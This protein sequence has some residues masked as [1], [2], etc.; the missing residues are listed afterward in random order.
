MALTTEEIIAT[1]NGALQIKG[2]EYDKN[3]NVVSA[4]LRTP[5]IGAYYSALAHWTISKRHAIIVMP[6][7]TGKT[8]TMVTLM[9]GNLMDKLLIIVPS[10]ALR[11]QIGERISKF[12]VLSEL[13]CISE[14]ATPPRIGYLK[15]GLKTLS[16]IEEF[17]TKFNVIIATASIFRNFPNGHLI[18]VASLC[19]H[20]FLDEAHHSQAP[21]TWMKIQKAFQNKPA[22]LFTATPYRNDELKL[23]GVEIYNYPLSKAQREGYFTEIEQ[24]PIY[25][26]NLKLADEAIA[27]KAVELLEKDHK[28]FP[29]HLLMARANSIARA[30]EIFTIYHKFYPQYNPVL[31]HSNLPEKKRKELQLQ[32]ENGESKIAVCVD[33]FGEGY[34]LPEIKIGAFHD[35]R[36]NITTALQLIGRFTRTKKGLGKAKFV[37]NAAEEQAAKEIQKLLGEDANWNILIPNLTE[38]KSRK[39][40]E[41]ST[42]VKSFNLPTKL[43]VQNLRP[44]LSLVVYKSAQDFWT[45]EKFREHF[46][47]KNLFH[48]NDLSNKKNTLIIVTAEKIQLD[49]MKSQEYFNI[50]H[51]LYV[52]HWLKKEKLLLIHSSKTNG[53]YYKGLAKALIGNDCRLVNGENVYRALQGIER[54]KFHGVGLQ[55]PHGTSVSYVQRAGKNVV[56]GTSASDLLNRSKRLLQGSGYKNGDQTNFGVSSKGRIWSL[57]RENIVDL[58]S[59]G[60]EIALKITDSSIDTS[61]FINHVA[62]PQLIEKRPQVRPFFI[63]W[64]SSLYS[65][66]YLKFSISTLSD[67][68][69]YIPN[70]DL[71]LHNPSSN[72]NLSFKI[73]TNDFVSH[74]ELRI[75]KGQQ[76]EIEHVGGP[77]LYFHDPSRKSL[78]EWLTENPPTIYFIDG[79]YLFDGNSYVKLGQKLRQFDFDKIRTIDWKTNGVNIRRESK[80]FENPEKTSIQF[81]LIENLKQKDSNY[82]LIFND[83]DKEE[84]ADIVTAKINDQTNQ[85]FIE[86]YHCKYSSEDN[87]GCRVGDLYEV[88]GQAQKNIR[89]LD[90]SYS[91][92]QRLISRENSLIN[93]NSKLTRIEKGDLA[94]L[95]SLSNKARRDYQILIKVFA[96]QPGMSKSKFLKRSEDSNEVERLFAVTEDYIKATK[97]GDFFVICSS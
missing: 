3:G 12:G 9:V 6:T 17:F 79:S 20:L 70:L 84:T 7:G 96:V 40:Q 92:F 57:Q 77:S 13:G 29:K 59:W 35:M 31:V 39:E 80:G 95:R 97:Q 75:N 28:T 67:K 62:F 86:L 53:N 44:A 38:G 58:I 50:E 55:E 49:W 11:E 42:F 24:H 83:D 87:E 33:M 5:Q 23:D 64:N 27:K 56:L 18:K 60:N 71:Q 22:L 25:E 82:D 4:G 10:K 15:K 61:S 88:L 47:S 54:L 94:L 73:A 76:F 90:D 69:Y 41:L 14:S 46:N 34:D 81:F 89:W 1:W 26:D 32:F 51:H 2:E 85:I 66:T 74:Y 16:D 63:E 91:F 65:T 68:F 21:K 37:F 52:V 78:T 19:S 36:R 45:P 30:E 72:G 48:I 8:D 43:P 93:K